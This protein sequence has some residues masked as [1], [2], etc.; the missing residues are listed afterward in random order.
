MGTGSF[1]GVKSGR[2]VT[3]TPHP[4]LVPWSRKSRAI[5]LLPLCA[6]CTEPQCLYKGAIYFTNQNLSHTRTST[7]VPTWYPIRKVLL[8]TSTYGTETS[9][10]SSVTWLYKGRLYRDSW[11]GQILLP[12]A[13]CLCTVCAFLLPA[14]FTVGIFGSFLEGKTARPGILFSVLKFWP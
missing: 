9:K 7:E 12:F 4:L 10:V 11:Q 1:L 13:H 5:P 2:G 14:P 3:L 6:A 8:L